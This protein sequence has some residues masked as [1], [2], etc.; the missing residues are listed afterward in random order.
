MYTDGSVSGDLSTVYGYSDFIDNS[1]TCSCSHG[2]YQS[3]VAVYDPNGSEVAYLE[4]AGGSS[5]TSAAINGDLGTYNVYGVFYL[6]CSCYGQIGG[7]GGGTPVP[8]GPCPFPNGETSHY[9]GKLP[10]TSTYVGLFTASLIPT[11]NASFANRTVS[12]HISTQSNF[13]TCYWDGSPLSPLTPADF[14]DGGIWTVGPANSYGLDLIGISTAYV[15]DYQAMMQ[16][17]LA[18]YQS[19]GWTVTQAMQIDSCGGPPQT[20]D[21]GHVAG[22]TI[23]YN[24]ATSVRGSA[25]GAA[26]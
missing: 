22:M 16:D 8:V 4:E 20:Y 7:G 23:T 12:E 13:D 10:P 25:Q 2:N 3:A 11:G 17:E 18:P 6:A 9:A 19:C 24:S 1:Q 14:D 5:A 26:Q 15:N 21:P